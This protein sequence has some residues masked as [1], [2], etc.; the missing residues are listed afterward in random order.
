MQIVAVGLGAEEVVEVGE[1]AGTLKEF[2]EVLDFFLKGH[3]QVGL[4]EPHIV[5]FVCED[6]LILVHCLGIEFGAAGLQVFYQRL[7]AVFVLQ[8][9][10]V[11][12]GP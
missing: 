12:F 1:D 2:V 4:L 10:L 8:V 11:Y 9:D 5:E 3:D 6:E 7:F